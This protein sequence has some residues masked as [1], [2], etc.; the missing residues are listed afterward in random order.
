M[1]YRH[2]ETEVSSD[3]AGGIGHGLRGGNADHGWFG[4]L[5]ARVLLWASQQKDLITPPRRI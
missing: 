2:G 3:S 1:D 5:K 4:M